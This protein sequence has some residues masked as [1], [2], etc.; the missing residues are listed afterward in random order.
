LEPEAAAVVAVAAPQEVAPNFL[1]VMCLGEAFH[2]L[3]IQDVESLILVGGGWRREG[4]K[5][6][7]RKKSL[8]RTEGGTVSCAPSLTG[9]RLSFLL[10]TGLNWG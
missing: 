2:R 9:V 5:E 1:C 8:W 6:E 3:R 7:K 10:L 4:N